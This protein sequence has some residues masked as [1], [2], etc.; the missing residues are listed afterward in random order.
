[1]PSGDISPE[2]TE[3]SFLWSGLSIFNPTG[4]YQQFGS[5]ITPVVVVS[6]ATVTISVIVT[7][8]A[9]Y[10]PF[11]N[12][13]SA[14]GTLTVTIS[15]MFITGSGYCFR[16][17]AISG[18]AENMNSVKG[19][20]IDGMNMRYTNTASPLTKQGKLVALQAPAAQ[21][22]YDWIQA[23]SGGF[24]ELSSTNQMKDFLLKDGMWGFYK[25]VDMDDFDMKVFTSVQEGVI[26]DSYW[27]IEGWTSYVVV[28][29]QC[30]NTAGQDGKWHYAHSVEYLTLDPWREVR[31]PR[32]DSKILAEACSRIGKVEQ[33]YENPVHI[34]TLMKNILG[35]TKMIAQGISH[36]GPKLGKLADRFLELP[37]F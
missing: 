10:S 15:N 31:A 1:V 6:G 16:H 25:A 11:F 22:W 8:D 33:F 37:I 24:N 20:R 32:F 30:S 19:I 35:T 14:G 26:V 29:C 13:N 27:P 7:A 3:N 34:P 21:H 4:G 9:Y 17:M 5:A 28:Y 12:G 23:N 36:Y 2:R 18:Y